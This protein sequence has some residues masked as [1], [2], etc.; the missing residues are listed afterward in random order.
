MNQNMK[1][2]NLRYREDEGGGC[3]VYSFTDVR[4]REY[5]D[6]LA[7]LLASG[8]EYIEQY[9]LGTAQVTVY[10]KGEDVLL[11]T[12]FPSI[13][14]A[15]VVTE[16][17]SAYLTFSDSPR[18]ERV[19]PLM[20]QID[21][22]DFGTSVVFRLPDGRFIIYDGGRE[23]EPDADKLVKCL[24]EQSPDSVPTVAAWIM[25]HPH[26]DHYRCFVT[27][28]EKYPDAFTVERFI[29]NFNDLSESDFERVPGLLKEADWLRRFEECVMRTGAQ[30]YRAHTGQVYEFSGARLEMLSTPDD[31][32]VVPVT[33]INSLSLV[34]KMTVAGQVV[35]LCADA[36]LGAMN[37]AGRYGEYLK[38]D[39]LQPPHHM[40]IG[41]DIDAYNLIDPAVC[42][43]PSFE[44]D[45]FAR[46]S[47]YQKR[48]KTENCHLFYN[49]NV[50]EFF[51]GSTGNVV[52]ALPYKPRS[53]GRKLYLEKLEK[54]RRSM[55]AES[56]FFMNLGVEDCDFSFVNISCEAAEV[57]AE[58]YGENVAEGY[59]HAIKLSVPA[60]QT[61]SFNI[62]NPEDADG[63]ALYYNPHSL[64]KKGIPEGA[65]FSVQ[66][67]SDIPIVIQGKKPADYH[68]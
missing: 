47:P 18:A 15:R 60:T 8:Y 11:S 17:G 34:V 44:D 23:F 41:G 49:L 20:T 35:M 62:F 5:F 22:E 54:Y 36:F 12:Y 4:E 6:Y 31:T 19:K 56:W 37:L 61:S 46:I 14:E 58:L 9:A 51:T 42:V 24:K 25:T 40:F 32:L 38:S 13:R 64:K 65:T 50:E 43:V 33:D 27:A 67:K 66:F 39:I 16:P 3:V 10:K 2:G 28:Y 7:S 48:C 59:V 30:V 57:F 26:C 53:N 52:L 63:D 68:D 21:L 29:Y 45:V 1:F 55:G